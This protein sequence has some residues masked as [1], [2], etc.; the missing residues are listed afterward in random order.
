MLSTVGLALYATA[1]CYVLFC[2]LST[3]KQRRFYAGALLSLALDM[4][5]VSFEFEINGLSGLLPRM[6]YLLHLTALGVQFLH[7]TNIMHHHLN[8]YRLVLSSEL[9]APHGHRVE[10]WR[11]LATGASTVY[12]VML[13]L[14]LVV[15]P[16]PSLESAF[17]HSLFF[18]SLVILIGLMSTALSLFFLNYVRAV[19]LVLSTLGE[20]QR[21]NKQ[22]L[23]RAAIVCCTVFALKSVSLVLLYGTGAELPRA[24]VAIIYHWTPLLVPTVALAHVHRIN[25]GTVEPNPVHAVDFGAA[26]WQTAAAALE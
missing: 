6:I 4:P 13:L 7:L 24:A 16:A 19:H 1:A 8:L 3:C 2:A 25:T 9:Y 17:S 10:Y 15:S 21:D 12:F 20:T 23:Q 22:R 5:F 14:Y 11:G 18:P 26:Q